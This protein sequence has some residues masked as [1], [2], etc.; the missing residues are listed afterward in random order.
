MLL[1]SLSTGSSFFKF[2]IILQREDAYQIANQVATAIFCII[3][4][5]K[6]RQQHRQLRRGDQDKNKKKHTIPN[7]S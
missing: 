6:V 1:Y 5:R 4:S 3:M 7:E 2:F